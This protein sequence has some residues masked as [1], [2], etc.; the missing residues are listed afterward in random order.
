MDITKPIEDLFSAKGLVVVITGGATVRG[1]H[2][3]AAGTATD[4]LRRAY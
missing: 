3:S 2:A 1:P 4:A